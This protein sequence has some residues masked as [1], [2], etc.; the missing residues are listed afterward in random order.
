MPVGWYLNILPSVLED[1]KKP[2][3][4]M[5]LEEVSLMFLELM[6]DF[7]PFWKISKISTI[8]SCSKDQTVPLVIH[9]NTLKDSCF[10]TV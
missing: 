4:I 2:G 1:I 7:Q 3:E 8:S 10:Y 6:D 9:P 5:R